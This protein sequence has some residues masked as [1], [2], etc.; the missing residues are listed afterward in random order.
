MSFGN[1]MINQFDP[2]V[3]ENGHD[4]NQEGSLDRTQDRWLI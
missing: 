1:V 2:F 3:I 4:N